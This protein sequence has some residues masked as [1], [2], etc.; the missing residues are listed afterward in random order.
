MKA[1]VCGRHGRCHVLLR[2][3]FE[4]RQ[5]RAAR[6][7]LL[8]LAVLGTFAGAASAQSTVT[9][10]GV[11][12]LGLRNVKNGSVSQKQMS[13]DGLTVNRIGFRGVEDLGG[14]L[15]AG[16][17]LEAG[18]LPDVGAAG[19]S[20]GLPAPTNGSS[21]L[22]N[23]RATVSLTGNWGEI[24]LGRDY[25][26]NFWNTAVAVFEPFGATGVASFL[27]IVNTSLGTGAIT[28]TRANNSVGYFL[29]NNLGGFY[30]QVQTS[31]GEG[32]DANKQTSARI[33]YATGPVN[34]SLASGVTDTSPNKYKHHNLGAA[35]NFGFMSLSAIYDLGEAGP[36]DQKVWQLGVDIPIGQHQIRAAYASAKI[37]N[38]NPAS[39]PEAKRIGLGYVYHLSKR[40]G[41]YGT[42]A[43][44]KN[45]NGAAFVVGA[46][47]GSSLN[48]KSTGYE[49][50]LR[51]SF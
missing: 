14:G 7:T 41:I 45:K 39:D 11:V 1:P 3:E 27:N 21:V 38:P 42:Y 30:G 43:Q 46:G 13:T 47:A 8:T 33:G 40:T 26:P 5:D 28:F 51:H 48:A 4:P 25:T 37:D 24:R 49:V 20:N 36:I 2:P 31:A 19:G 9:L 29:P 23:R 35:Y 15:S 6:K 34:V 12:D 16:F 50:G 18:M 22:F 32:V 44:I 17:W 10:F